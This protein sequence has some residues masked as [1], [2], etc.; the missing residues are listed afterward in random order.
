M[1]N[2]LIQMPQGAKPQ[3]EEVKIEKWEDCNFYKFAKNEYSIMERGWKDAFDRESDRKKKESME[4]DHEY[5]KMVH[6]SVMKLLELYSRES[7]SALS[8]GFILEEFKRLAAFKPLTPLLGDESEWEDCFADSDGTMH[9]Q[10]KR[11]PHVF[12]I[13]GDNSTAEDC[14]GIAFSTD[15][16]RTWFTNS[17]SHVKISFPYV[18]KD[19]IERKLIT[20][21]EKAEMDKEDEAKL[22]AYLKAHPE[23]KMMNR[24]EFCKEPM[25]GQPR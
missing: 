15:E 5:G 21:E 25:Y 9:Q 12:R 17:H 11:C 1:D 20:K 4:K 13:K 8:A 22:N 6:E 10:N 3:Q 24:A 14:E 7:G 23:V 18:V 2:K 16:G 19:S